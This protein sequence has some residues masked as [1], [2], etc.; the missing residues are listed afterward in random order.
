MLKKKDH[1]VLN[2]LKSLI[3]PIMDQIQKKY[4]K[5]RTPVVPQQAIQYLYDEQDPHYVRPDIVQFRPYELGQD[6]DGVPGL[7]AA[8]G[9]FFYNLE[10]TT[11]EERLSNGFYARPKD[12]L[13]DIRSLAKDAK[14]IGD[15]ERLLKANELVTNVEV[16]I[17]TIEANPAMADCE[18]VYQ[19]Q[20]KR[21]EDRATK[22]KKRA[23]LD[24]ALN[25][26]VGPD[27]PVHGQD[28][29]AD[30]SGPITLGEVIPGRRMLTTTPFTTPSSLSNGY[31]AASEQATNGSMVPSRTSGD[32]IH[33][34]GT[35]DGHTHETPTGLHT[36]QPPTSQNRDLSHSHGMSNLSG[37]NTQNTQTSALQHLPHDTSPSA[38][39]NDASTTTSGKKTSDGTNTQVTNGRLDSQSSPL[40]RNPADRD[41][42][43]TQRDTQP[44]SQPATQ[45]SS[46]DQW[47]HSQAHGLSRGQIIQHYSQTTSSGSQ[48]SSQSRHLL[49]DAPP[50]P[51]TAAPLAD[52]LNGPPE[53]L[54]S[55]SVVSSQDR[56]HIDED[57]MRALL[58]EFTKK[59]GG[60]SI[61]QLEQINRELMNTVWQLRGEYNRSKVAKEVMNVFNETIAD[62]EEMQRLLQLS[63]E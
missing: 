57:L 6:K 15:K 42:P 27:I 20:L 7:R 4:R 45:S 61:E 49:F 62:I 52:I 17:A 16:D 44:R 59:S 8:D 13:A 40:D 50:R 5:F 43:D 41:L 3:Q 53:V 55:S 25:P 23:E 60:C 28:V 46:E 10:T 1:L 14:H 18:N 24:A 19:R 21:A 33:M 22:Y 47:L 35:D 12:F 63:Q 58:P 26:L 30:V 54:S 39:I 36:M 9:K 2:V 37:V 32:D 31:M 56:Y 11:I 34:G 51:S 48:L 29:I 38:L